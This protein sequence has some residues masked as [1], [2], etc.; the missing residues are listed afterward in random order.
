MSNNLQM[1]MSSGTKNRIAWE[2][3]LYIIEQI[4]I[5]IIIIIIV[6]VVVV[7]AESVQTTL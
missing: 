1:T 6:V 7:V 4:F 3:G 5:I 2:D